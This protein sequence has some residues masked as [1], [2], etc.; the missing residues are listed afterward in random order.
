MNFGS[1]ELD[2]D[3]LAFWRE[4]RGF[5]AEHVTD[6]L[7]DEERAN[8]GGF[9]EALHLAMGE[10]G[11]VAPQWSTAEGGAGLDPR[12]AQIIQH[13]FYGSGAP[14]ILAGTTLLPPIAI[15]IF[16]SPEIQAEILPRVADG[17]VRICLGYTEPD[18]GSDLAAV[19]TRA[20]RD[21]DD[22]IINGQ[23]MFTTGAQFSQYCFLLTRTDPTVP[24]HKGL[25]VFLLPLDTPGVEIRPIDT[26][27]GERTNFVYLQDVRI[28]DRWRLGE[29]NQGWSVVAAPLNAEH[30]IRPEEET[31]LVGGPYLA[32]CERLV[33][34]FIEWAHQQTGSAGT[35]LDEEAV[36]EKLG[37][38]LLAAELTRSAD[39]PPARILSS[40]LLNR[41]ASQLIALVGPTA[42]LERGA[43]DAASAG[44]FEAG[45]RFAPATAIYGGSTDI[46][47]NVIAERF[48]G[49][50]RSTPRRTAK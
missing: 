41:T 9:N 23:K 3:T 10:R 20:E 39:G 37:E 12:R 15:R 34:A 31:T 48:L 33:A 40:E 49:L 32:E 44:A 29:V 17:T 30:G 22:W 45:F 26:L 36:Q 13:E 7:L 46:A 8:G 11:W 18:C 38:I 27:G 50:P 21:G 2:Q 47:R 14:Y 6:E 43:E 5:F 35:L 16:G 19:R 24:A 1:I 42:L 4:V 25:T 28:D